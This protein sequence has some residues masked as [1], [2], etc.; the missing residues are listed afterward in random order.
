LICFGGKVCKDVYSLQIE[1]D[2]LPDNGLKLRYELIGNM[3]KLSIPA[4]QPPAEIEGLWNHTCFEAFVAV[5]GERG[6]REFNFSPSGQWAAFGFSSNRK[7]SDWKSAR[8]PEIMIER[9]QV[10]CFRLEANI[11]GEDM[12]SNVG[13]K[14][15]QLGLTAV[16]ESSDGNLSF[17]ALTHPS[18]RPDFHLRDGFTCI[19]VPEK[20]F[21]T[22]S[23]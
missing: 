15:L 10:G 4:P 8:F 13:E 16:V 3:T 19:L 9:D 23:D 2:T 7:R 20:T 12:P 1:V 14:P 17:W 5:E 22:S 21:R 6:Y 11:A 18:D